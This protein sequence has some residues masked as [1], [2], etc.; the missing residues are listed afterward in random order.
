MT[1]SSIRTPLHC[2]LLAASLVSIGC[3]SSQDSTTG[4]VAQAASQNSSSGVSAEHPEYANWKQFP[5]GTSLVRKRTAANELSKIV[6]TTTLRLVEKDESKVVVESQV[7]VERPNEAPTVNPASTTTF[8]SSFSIPQG[9]ELEQFQLPSLKAKSV[10][11]ET[12]EVAGRSIPATVY[13]WTESNESGPM[14]VRIW[15]SNEVPGRL[16]KQVNST[17]NLKSTSEEE[18]VEWSGTP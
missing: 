5:V 17:P 2:L 16:A 15:Q 18:V 13:E 1:P 10:G 8:P 12:I 14:N 4:S 6:V 11:S 9:M 3:T 7:T